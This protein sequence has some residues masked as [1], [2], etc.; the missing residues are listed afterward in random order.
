M[1]LKNC[2][3]LN[4]ESGTKHIFKNIN[5]SFVVFFF[6]FLPDRLVSSFGFDYLVLFSQILNHYFHLPN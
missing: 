4:F 5:E 1:I 2:L 3:N 6:F